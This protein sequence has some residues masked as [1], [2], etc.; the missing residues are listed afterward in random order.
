MPVELT[1]E[2]L[3]IL[4]VLARSPVALSRVQIVERL[5]SSIEWMRTF[6]C[7]EALTESN[8]IACLYRETSEPA[9]SVPQRLYL[10]LASGREA[11]RASGHAV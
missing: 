9:S 2:H 6:N 7:L 8:Y 5:A 10:L 3:T 11:L 4:R 1:S